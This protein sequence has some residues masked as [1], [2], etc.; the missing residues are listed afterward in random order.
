M[1]DK[2]IFGDQEIAFL[3][4]LVRQ[5]VAFMIVGL[6]AAALQGAPVVTQDVD[7]WFRDLGDHGIRIALKKVGG[8]LV[9]ATDTTPPMFAGKG[10][11]LFDVV[12]HMHGLGSFDEEKT[13]TIKVPLGRTK[14]SAL[15]LE[16]IIAS[17]QFLGR[18]KDKL[19]LK[20]LTDAL[21]AIRERERRKR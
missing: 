12:V 7:L 19:A 3:Q 18:D 6:S 16:R 5:K 11:E 20:P 13:N 2:L 15:K 10:I 21:A 8:A 1:A 14:V 4:E 17:K 9:P